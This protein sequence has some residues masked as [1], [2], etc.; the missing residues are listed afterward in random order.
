MNRKINYYALYFFIGVAFFLETSFLPQLFPALFVPNLLV[1][2][3]IATGII[4]CTED[5]LYIA[6]AVGLLMDFY[7]AS[8]FGIF[9]LSMVL[10]SCMVCILRARFLKEENWFKSVFVSV[11]AMLSYYIIFFLILYIFSNFNPDV[12]DLDFISK[13][14]IFDSVMVTFLIGPTKFMISKK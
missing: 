13:K 8:Y 3:I 2:I 9:S 7:S 14:I 12:F 4:F 11:A 5:F 1:L 6:F 10:L